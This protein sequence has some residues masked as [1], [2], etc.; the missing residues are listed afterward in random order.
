MVRSAHLTGSVSR[1][2]GGLFDAILRLGQAQVL[3]GMSV[4]VIGLYDEFTEADREAWNPVHVFACRQP[5]PRVM[6]RP[7]GYMMELQEFQQAVMHTHGLW[8][9]SSIAAKN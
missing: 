2:A 6:R 3:Q 4:K 5:R 9:Y 8:L 1:N 7:E